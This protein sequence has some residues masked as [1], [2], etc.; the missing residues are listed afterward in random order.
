MAPE[1]FSITV[2]L[3]S[4]SSESETVKTYL[5]SF[6]ISNPE[7]G[8]FCWKGRGLG[9]WMNIKYGIGA[10]FNVQIILGD[11]QDSF[12]DLTFYGVGRF[13]MVPLGST[14]VS[15]WWFITIVFIVIKS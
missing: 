1:K 7:G 12:Y 2:P 11:P 10:T 13:H 14:W 15:P 6:Q 8:W 9:A 5:D 4:F 3:S